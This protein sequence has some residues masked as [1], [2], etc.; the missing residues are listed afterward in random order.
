VL[1]IP[2]V[3]ALDHVTA[4]KVKTAGLFLILG[5]GLDQIIFTGQART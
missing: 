5:I 2:V 1:A 4:L 3:V